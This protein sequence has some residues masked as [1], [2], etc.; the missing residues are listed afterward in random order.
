MMPFINVWNNNAAVCFERY[1]ILIIFTK[2]AWGQERKHYF[3]ILDE[4][5]EYQN[6]QLL[7]YLLYLWFQ[8]ISKLPDHHRTVF[9]Y[10]MAFLKELLNHSI[11]NEHD[12]KRLGRSLSMICWFYCMNVMIFWTTNCGAV[13]EFIPLFELFILVMLQSTQS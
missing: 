13:L 4:F 5:Q 11:D 7:H 2:T 12:I 8:I 6:M 3:L 9:T 1:I 10:L